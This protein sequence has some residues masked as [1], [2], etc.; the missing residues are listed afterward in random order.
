MGAATGFDPPV[1]AMK[2]VFTFAAEIWNASRGCERPVEKR[3]LAEITD[4]MGMVLP[5]LSRHEV[6]D[7]VTRM[8]GF[9][10]IRY[11]E[12]PRVVVDI[13]VQRLG[14]DRF[15]VLAAGMRSD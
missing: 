1:E 14:P 15:H 2:T 4:K 10:V 12:D 7:L 11:G 8:H 9:S 5:E 6:E 3:R 13:D